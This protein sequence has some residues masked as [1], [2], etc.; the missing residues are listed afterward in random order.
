MNAQEPSFWE[1]VDALSEREPR[2]RREAYGF[3]VAALGATVRALPESRKADIDRRHLSGAELVIGVVRLARA[4]FGALADAVFREWGVTRSEDLGAI[5]FQLVESGQLSARPEDSLEDFSGG[6][7]LL[8]AL[9]GRS[10][11]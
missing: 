8:E 7:D 3:V 6:P 11:R 4:E 1:V 2:F 10:H 9:S 5:V